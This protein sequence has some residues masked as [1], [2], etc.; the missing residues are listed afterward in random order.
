MA[1]GHG[2]EA[3]G[4]GGVGVEGV[5]GSGDLLERELAEVGRGD[6]RG[7]DDEDGGGALF[8]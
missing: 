5:E 2:L 7:I 6:A 1:M 3:F 4:G 8:Q